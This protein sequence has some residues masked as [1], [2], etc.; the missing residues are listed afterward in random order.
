MENNKTAVKRTI[1]LFLHIAEII[2]DSKATLM[3]LTTPH[4]A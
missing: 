3:L 2:A 1:T 4:N